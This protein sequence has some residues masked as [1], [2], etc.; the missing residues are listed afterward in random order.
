MNAF[1]FDTLKL[2]RKLEAAGF[3]PEQAAGA[4]A[5]LAETLGEVPGV[6]RKEDVLR[7]G[8]DKSRNYQMDVRHYRI[9]NDHHPRSGTCPSLGKV[10]P[11]YTGVASREH[12]AN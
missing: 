9:P 5:A 3:S 8:A 2:A 11:W 1:T 7:L 6:A 12:S 10:S 4:S